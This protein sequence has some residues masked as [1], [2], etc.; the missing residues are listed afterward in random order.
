M[1]SDPIQ[2]HDNLMF[3]LNTRGHGR[4]CHILRTFEEAKQQL[5]RWQGT[6]SFDF[7]RAIDLLIDYFRKEPIAQETLDQFEQIAKDL[8]DIPTLA[9][10]NA[11]QLD[12]HEVSVSQVKLALRAAYEVGRASRR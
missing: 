4:D 6:H 5:E 1:Q 11:D 7:T 8:L 3:V 2:I 9:D 12:F 10:R